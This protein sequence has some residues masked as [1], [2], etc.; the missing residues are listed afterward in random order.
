MQRRELPDGW[1]ADIPSFDADPDGIAT[2]KASNEVLNAIAP[3]VPWLLSGSA[4]LTGSAASGLTFDEAGTF[5][6]ED[7]SGRSPPLRHPRARVGGD[8]QR[9][10][11]HQAAPASGRPT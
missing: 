9:A 5:S 8:L 6:P 11:A 2:R 10:G 4:D 1:D 3:R 7:R